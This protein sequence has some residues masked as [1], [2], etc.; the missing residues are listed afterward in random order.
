MLQSLNQFLQQQTVSA[1]GLCV[2]GIFLG[3]GLAAKFDNRFGYVIILVSAG[4][5]FYTLKVAGLLPF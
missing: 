1:I 4:V 2:L 5:L 3:A